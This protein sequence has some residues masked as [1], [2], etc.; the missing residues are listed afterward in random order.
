MLTEALIA[1][2]SV[3]VIFLIIMFLNKKKK[4]EQ[5]YDEMQ[6]KIRADG[7]RIAYVTTL[8]VMSVFILFVYLSQIQL[9]AYQ[10]GAILIVIAMSGIMVFGIYCII[11]DSFFFIGQDWKQYFIVCLVVALANGIP[12]VSGL[13]KS[14]GTDGGQF[15]YTVIT[16]GFMLIMFLSY[17]VA[18]GIKMTGGA[19]G[20]EE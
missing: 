6:E 5:H 2:A 14:F 1:V 3:A 15:D 10:L 16:N 8:V 17:A 19:R 18:I 7:Y 20:S 4:A 13:V 12:F 9:Q 11:H